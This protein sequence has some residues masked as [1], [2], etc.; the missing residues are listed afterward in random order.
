MFEVVIKRMVACFAAAVISFTSFATVERTASVYHSYE[1][2]TVADTPAPS[3]F[4]PFYIAHYGRHG[5]R[6]LTGTFAAD[7]LEVLEKA[8]KDGR[9]TD[10]GKALLADVR[11]IADAHAGM[12][13]QLT[14]RGAEEHRKLARRM[15][16][17][18][19]EV[20]ANARRV[21][22]Q[23]SIYPRVLIS[24]ANFT[25]AL[26]DAAPLLS[27]DFVTGDKFQDLLNGPQLSRDEVNADAKIRDAVNVVARGIV[28]PSPLTKRC[29]ASDFATGD[30]L[31]FV[32]DLFVCASI[33]QCMSRELAGLDIYCYFH[34]DEIDALSRALAVEDYAAFANS[35]EFGDIQLRGSRNLARDFAIRAEE[36][37]ADGSIAADLRFGHDSGLWPFVGLLGL[38]GPGDRVPFAESWQ[39]CPA[40]KWMPM[41]SNIQMVFDRNDVG[42]VLVKILYNE[43]EM[44]IKGHEPVVDSFY[45]WQIVRE[46]LEQS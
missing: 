23:S 30:S 11:K 8:E 25:M 46:K 24:Q 43:R 36:A 29:F 21:R 27:F 44:R 4:T 32:R 13:G 10:E 33:C 15:F 42:E 3:E 39:K 19:P 6:R 40:W 34:A 12:V 41:A 35:Q 1:F 5:S 9:L 37:I 18:F 14:E 16:E 26:K 45:R 22:C 31:K 7:A 17:R 38:E 20:F 28:D 2:T